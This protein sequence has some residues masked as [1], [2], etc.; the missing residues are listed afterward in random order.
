MRGGQAGAR[1]W[2]REGGWPL[3]WS[4]TA[5]LTT[6][7][8]PLPVGE[9]ESA[10]DV[11]VRYV[12]DYAAC[13]AVRTSH[14]WWEAALALSRQGG[15]GAEARA[16]G[17][18]E[19]RAEEREALARGATSRDPVDLTADLPPDAAAPA[20]G[21]AGP[22]TSAAAAAAAAE[23]A[24]VRS[25]LRSQPMPSSLAAFKKDPPAARR[26]PASPPLL[27]TARAPGVQDA[28]YVL[29]RD[30]GRCEALHPTP[31]LAECHRTAE[32]PD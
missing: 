7:A 8:A 6:G 3:R 10:V 17:G 23:A 27:L 26:W 12:P 20:A 32:C 5:G 28:H 22:S 4:L 30:L 21:H 2:V 11:T 18:E 19:G 13:R 15:A 14:E 25:R 16:G 24:E 9:D 31:I 29:E 1:G